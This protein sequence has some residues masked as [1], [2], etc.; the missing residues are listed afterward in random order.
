MAEVKPRIVVSKCLGFDACRWNGVTIPSE[1]IDLIKPH[2]EII[3]VCPEVAIQL[4]VPRAP[5]RIIQ[6]KTDGL[7]LFQPESGLYHTDAMNRFTSEFLSDLPAID[8]FILKSKSPSCGIR[9]VKRYP[10][11][12]K[13]AVSGMGSGFFGGAVLERFP[14]SAIEDEARLTHYR[15]RDHFLT[16]LFTYTRFRHLSENF[17][18][19][20]LVAFQRDHKLI[21]MAYNQ[22]RMR[23]LGRIVA[24]HQ[25]LMEADVLKNYQENL[26]ALFDKMPSHRAHINVLMH[27]FGYATKQMAKGE[28]T[29]FLALLDRYRS[30][31]IPLSVP[32]E[33][34]RSIILRFSIDYLQGQY[35][36]SPYPPD[37]YQITDS[38]KGRNLKS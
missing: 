1:I 17:S 18:M 2:V 33:V 8:G 22:N 20:S 4:G 15:I 32:I 29:H 19:K 3:T 23:I 10:R 12:G 36:F 24:N 30:G 26:I 38:G 25:K 37:L 34:I 9:D 6:N 7:Q 13:V 21:F 16:K 14:A 31:Q 28:K 27:A 5:V 35:Y 11:E